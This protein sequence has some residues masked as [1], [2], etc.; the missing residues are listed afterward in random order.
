VTELM[1][2]PQYTPLSIAEM[3]IS[4][5]AANEGYL[6]DVDVNKIVAFEAAMHSYM[7]ANQAELM[8]KVN[9]SGDWNDEL[10]AAFHA[11]LKAFKETGTW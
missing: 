10:E 4:L 6:D 3:A 9:A 11:A 2:Q 1:K 8:D 5:F 7:A